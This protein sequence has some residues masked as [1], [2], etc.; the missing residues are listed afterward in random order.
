MLKNDFIRQ[1][2]PVNLP[3]QPSALNI[4]NPCVQ[5]AALPPTLALLIQT[6]GRFDTQRDIPLV[7][8]S[9]LPA[10]DIP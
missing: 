9:I 10:G 6:K 4:F 2:Q 8:F 3:E 1:R 7:C 5:A